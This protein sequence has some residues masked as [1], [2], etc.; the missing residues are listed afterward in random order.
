MTG[1]NVMFNPILRI[2]VSCNPEA[3]STVDLAAQLQANT[4]SASIIKGG[5]II[6]P[7]LT[8]NDPFDPNKTEYIIP[9]E[10]DH[11]KYTLLIDIAEC[12]GW[13]GPNE[14]NIGQVVCGMSGKA[15]KPYFIPRLNVEPCGKHAYFSVPE[16]CVSVQADNENI[17][18]KEVKI[19]FHPE[20][21]YATLIEKEY[22]NGHV[23]DLPEELIRFK[24][25]AGIA[26]DK[27]NCENC[28][29]V[30]YYVDT[31]QIITKPRKKQY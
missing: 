27:S 17:T 28:T 13:K 24:L 9:E 26:V 22:Y 14:L 3:E 7:Q 20:E 1:E 12:G 31:N 25:A 23:E 11:S 6:D 8:P 4:R 16:G 29:H 18:I 15:L 21:H 30:H 5:I 10:I 2:K 19:D